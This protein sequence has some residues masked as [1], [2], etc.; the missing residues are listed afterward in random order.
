MR[1]HAHTQAWLLMSNLICESEFFHVSFVL[2]ISI[3][4]M[5]A[6]VYNGFSNDWQ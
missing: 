6:S 4:C 5:A 1:A 3:N 2:K